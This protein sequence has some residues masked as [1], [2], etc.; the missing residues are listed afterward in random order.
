MADTF[1]GGWINS[2]VKKRFKISCVVHNVN[3][4]DILEQLILRWIESDHIKDEIKLLVNGKGEK[5]S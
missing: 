3:Q 2:D 1:I 4:Q 5:E